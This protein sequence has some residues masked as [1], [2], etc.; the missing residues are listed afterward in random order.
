MDHECL[1]DWY[2]TK[3]NDQIGLRLRILPWDPDRQ[4][5]VNV[6]RLT[7]RLKKKIFENYEY[8]KLFIPGFVRNQ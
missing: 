3:Q 7:P 1:L 8:S 6:M 4:C 2:E 5:P